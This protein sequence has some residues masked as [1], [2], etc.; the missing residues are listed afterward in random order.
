MGEVKVKDAIGAKDAALK[1]L[2]EH[3]ML[4]FNNEVNSI[5]K[6][7]VAWFVMVK[8]VKFIGVVI[9]KSTTAEVLA[10]VKF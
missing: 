7:D 9:V 1:Y 5:F 2:S 3:G 6:K 4:V 8:S 10:A